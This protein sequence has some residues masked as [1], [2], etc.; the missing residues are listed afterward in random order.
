MVAAQPS[1]SSRKIS[2]LQQPYP[3][4]NQQGGGPVAS[5]EHEY[6]SY[7]MALVRRYLAILYLKFIPTFT[8][9]ILLLYAYI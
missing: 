5:T 1:K 4:Y 8:Y 2:N 3:G 9:Y 6:W 7:A